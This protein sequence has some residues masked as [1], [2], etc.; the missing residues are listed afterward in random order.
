MDDGLEMHAFG[1]DQRKAFG[2]VEAH[3]PAEDAERTGAGAIVLGTA[4][5][6]NVTQQL[7]VLAHRQA[8]IYSR[9]TRRSARSRAGPTRSLMGARLRRRPPSAP[10]RDAR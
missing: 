2:Q 7:K 6:E 10:R 1:R 8:P 4:S 5:L 9:R 3:L